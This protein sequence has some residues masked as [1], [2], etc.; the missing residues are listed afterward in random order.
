M[1]L[2][3]LYRLI[4]NL[5]RIGSVTEIDFE[6]YVARVITGENT[7]DWIRWAALRAGT[8]ATWWA[9]SVG[10]QVILFAPGGDL[11]N[12]VIWGS[13]YSDSVPPPDTGECSDVILFPDGARVSYDPETGALIATGV[14]SATVKASESISATAPKIT[15]TATT[16]ITLD[17]PE[18]ICTKKL[19]CATFEMKQGGKMTGNIEHSG[20][21]I[22][23][24]GVVVHT[25]KHGGVERGGS[26]TDGPQ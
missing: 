26:Q 2:N 1:N 16:S 11:E 14:K 3:E 15:C 9:P 20:G 17:T 12:A 23:S 19:S 13:L 6:R 21:S 7:T 8:A 24:N 4:C 25:H 18:V 10:E 22:T 5:V